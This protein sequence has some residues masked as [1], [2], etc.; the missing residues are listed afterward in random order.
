MKNQKRAYLDALCEAIQAAEEAAKTA[1]TSSDGGTCNFDTATL[2]PDGKRFTDVDLDFIRESTGI[3][4]TR[5]K[6]MGSTAFWLGF[7]AP[8]QGANRTRCHEA[9][10][11]VMKEY[12][13][14]CVM[15]YQMD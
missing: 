8:G 11:K 7:T 6:W 2:I 12:G 1:S 9:A 4:M 15:Y 10:C 13:H 3:D 14:N 5:F